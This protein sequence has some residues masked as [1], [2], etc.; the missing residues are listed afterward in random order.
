MIEGRSGRTDLAEV[1]WNGTQPG[2]SPEAKHSEMSQPGAF[3][4][5]VQAESLEAGLEPGGET[6]SL[7]ALVFQDEHPDTPGLAVLPHAEHDSLLEAAGGRGERAD[8]LVDTVGRRTPQERE[9]DVQVLRAD[10]TGPGCSG[11]LLLLPVNELPDDVRRK[12]KRAEEADSLIVHDASRPER[13]FVCPAVPEP[14]AEGAGHSQPTLS[15]LLSGSPEARAVAQL[16]DLVPRRAGRR[17]RPASPGSPHP[18]QQR[19]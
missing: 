3:L 9:G 5:P 14:A 16:A 17:V 2:P 8:D 6:R 13:A 18:G 11:E 4:Q 1:G 19:R 10:E 12:G 15:E 7:A